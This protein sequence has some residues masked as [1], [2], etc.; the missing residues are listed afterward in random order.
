MKK[1]LIALCVL[2]VIGFIC[3]LTVLDNHNSKYTATDENPDTSESYYS[4]NSNSTQYIQ[5]STKDW[6]KDI[7]E[8]AAKSDLHSDSDGGVYY[9][10]GKGD[11][12]PNKTYNAFD[13]Y[14]SSCDSNND[15]IED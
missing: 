11:T 2:L 5:D 1:I 6:M 3:Y 15:N 7:G 14:C 4:S 9:C 8:E 10:M 13:L 12:C